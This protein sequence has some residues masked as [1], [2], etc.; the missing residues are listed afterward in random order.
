[1]LLVRGRRW[2]SL[3]SPCCSISSLSAPLGEGKDLRSV[4]SRISVACK[5]NAM[6]GYGIS[7]PRIL[8]ALTMLKSTSF[9]RGSSHGL[10]VDKDQIAAGNK[11]CAKF[12]EGKDLSGFRNQ[13]WW[14]QSFCT[15]RSLL[16][17]RQLTSIYCPTAKSSKLQIARSQRFLLPCAQAIYSY[18]LSQAGTPCRLSRLIE[19]CS[20]NISPLSSP[21]IVSRCPTAVVVRF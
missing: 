17:C 5:S 11:R 7:T 8:I 18:V 19:C 21:L 2:D 15:A 10:R 6:P 12:F 20:A 14:Q 16:H 9:N 3:S 4:F 1:M 13:R